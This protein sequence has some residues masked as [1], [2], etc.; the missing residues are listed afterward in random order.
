[1]RP[2]KSI[3]QLLIARLAV[4][5]FACSPRMSG[6][7]V[8]LALAPTVGRR[9]A[10]RMSYC[11]RACAML[12]TATRRSRLLRSA[13][14]TSVCSFGS[15]K[16]WSQGTS[17]AALPDLRGRIREGR[18]TGASGRSYLGMKEQPASSSAAARTESWRMGTSY[19][20]PAVAPAGQLSRPARACTA[21]VALA[22]WK[23]AADTTKKIGRRTPRRPVPVSI[24]AQHACADGAPLARREPAPDEIASGSTPRPKASEVMRWDGSAG[25][26]GPAPDSITPLPCAC[27]SLGELDD[28]DG[29]LRRQ[30][31]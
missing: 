11:A 7:R 24:R 15:W 23:V 17:A 31:R 10:R 27:R 9:S 2:K 14:A 20:V 1:M 22:A 13:V 30:G 18:G 28:Q 19:L 4:Y 29:V 5:R 21:C 25:A 8:P 26:R 16:N 6:A 12:S 3:S